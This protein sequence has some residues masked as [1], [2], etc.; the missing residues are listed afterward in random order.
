MIC[1]KNFQCRRYR[2]ISNKVIQ[3]K[4]DKALPII[5]KFAQC[6]VRH[7]VFVIKKVLN[8]TRISVTENLPLKKEKLRDAWEEH[9]FLTFRTHGSQ[10]LFKDDNTKV[11]VYND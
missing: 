10:I 4:K 9:T 7:R 11:K 1:P 8:G 5:V 3:G 2:Q 6:S